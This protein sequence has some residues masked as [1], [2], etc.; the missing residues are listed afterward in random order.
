MIAVVLDTNVL[1]SG[2]AQAAGPAGQ[3]LRM[4][5]EGRFNLV[6]SEH[7]FAELARTFQKGYFLRLLGP[8]RA[9]RNLAL[10][11]EAATWTTV[12]EDVRGVASHPE[13]DLVL[14]T[15]VSGRADYLVTGDRQLQ[16][17]GVYRNVV[18]LSPCTLLERLVPS[19]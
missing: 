18:V 6:I 12:I 2:F 11:R 16:S 14:T 17:V 4:W 3:L 5:L 1:A 13:D 19:E 7:L 10:L 8:E 9:A 15:A